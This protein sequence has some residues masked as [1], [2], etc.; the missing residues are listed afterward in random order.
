M[1]LNQYSHD[2]INLDWP[3]PWLDL[4]VVATEIFP[5]SKGPPLRP[6]PSFIKEG[7]G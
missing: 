5:L 7:W 1:H 4:F 6:A 2:S 3:L